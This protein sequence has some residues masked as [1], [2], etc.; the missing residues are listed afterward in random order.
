MK[1]KVAN[2]VGISFK[3]VTAPSGSL[4]GPALFSDTTAI[5][6]ECRK[7]TG[8]VTPLASMDVSGGRTGNAAVNCITLLSIC[9]A[10]QGCKM[11]YQ[12]LTQQ[13]AKTRPGGYGQISKESIIDCG[14]QPPI[15]EWSEHFIPLVCT[16]AIF[17][18]L[19]TDIKK[20]QPQAASWRKSL[21]PPLHP[22]ML[23]AHQLSRS[24]ACTPEGPR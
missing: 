12:H 7:R 3:E 19:H 10:A 11:W 13:L 9:A 17:K 16:E 6:T 5:A 14:I 15:W 2:R 24:K 20:Q 4:S 18:Q 21:T 1:S 8:L 22:P 23:Q